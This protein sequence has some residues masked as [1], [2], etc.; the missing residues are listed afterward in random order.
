M[1]VCVSIKMK[2]ENANLRIWRTLYAVYRV[3]ID[4]LYFFR[5]SWRILNHIIVVNQ[6]LT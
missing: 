2:E 1:N 3:Y 5:V 4:A 6:N